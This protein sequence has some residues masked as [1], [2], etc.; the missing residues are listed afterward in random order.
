MSYYAVDT[1][2]LVWYLTNDPRLGSQAQSILTDPA[3]SLV[4]PTVVLAEVQY[5]AAQRRV[6]LCFTDILSVIFDDPRCLVYPL[7][8]FVLL[9]LPDELNIHDRLIIATGILYQKIVDDEVIVL[10]R[11]EEIKQA[12][13]LPTLW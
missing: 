10:T 8:T 7:D 12:G 11:D 5:L 9:Y 1:H 2:A 6:P 4:I 3:S 13:L